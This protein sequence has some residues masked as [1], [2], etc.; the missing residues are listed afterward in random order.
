MLQDLKRKW[1]SRKPRPGKCVMN[2]RYLILFGSC[3]GICCFNVMNGP[4]KCLPDS[5]KAQNPKWWASQH[6]AKVLQGPTTLL[7][8]KKR[9]ILHIMDSIENVIT[10]SL[11]LVLKNVVQRLPWRSSLHTQIILNDETDETKTLCTK[12]WNILYS[13]WFC[14]NSAN[15]IPLCPT[16]STNMSRRSLTANNGSRTLW[17]VNCF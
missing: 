2:G 3:A 11:S 9:C 10:L 15:W 17:K 14:G 1:S 7:S 6:E 12:T 4:V 13:A 8:R 16:L 5:A